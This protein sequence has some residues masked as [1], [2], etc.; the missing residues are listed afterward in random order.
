M[1]RNLMLA[2]GLFTLA[3]ASAMAAPAATVARTS[4]HVANA[5][6][7]PPADAAKK[8]KKP[9]KNKKANHKTHDGAKEPATA[10]APAK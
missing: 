6:D 10:P 8:N 9:P 7:P 2:V 3:G 5:E 4:N 1:I